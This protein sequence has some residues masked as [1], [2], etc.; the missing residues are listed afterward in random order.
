MTYA[1]FFE[2]KEA[3]YVTNQ[4]SHQ[5]L[6]GHNCIYVTPLVLRTFVKCAFTVLM[7]S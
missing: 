3:F 6:N 4:S 2:S 1:T 7:L 5:F